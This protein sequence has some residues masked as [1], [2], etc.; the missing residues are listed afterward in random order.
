M[1]RKT[2]LCYKAPTSTEFVEMDKRTR[3]SGVQG[4]LKVMG[5]PIENFFKVG[6]EE[7]ESDFK[8]NV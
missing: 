5:L 2:S 8:N 6:K 3:D 7:K 1:I 4:T